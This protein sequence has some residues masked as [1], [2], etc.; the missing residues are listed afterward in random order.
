MEDQY[1]VL[2]Q[3]DALA[4][5]TDWNQFRNPDFKKIRKMLHAPVIFDG[6]NLYS[7]SLLSTQGFVYFGIGRPNQG[8]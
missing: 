6:R 4:V 3:A 1:Q 2:E 7:A 5:V 8:N